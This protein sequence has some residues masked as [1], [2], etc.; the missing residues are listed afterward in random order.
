MEQNITYLEKISVNKLI[1]VIFLLLLII[2]LFSA[3]IIF[4]NETDKNIRINGNYFTAYPS[5]LSN[6]SL[7]PAELNQK[8]LNGDIGFVESVGK[9]MERDKYITK[10]VVQRFRTNSKKKA[11]RSN[12]EQNSDVITASKFSIEDNF[13][14]FSYRE[15]KV[16]HKFKAG[17]I[18]SSGYIPPDAMGAVGPS[19][20]VY[21]VNGRIITYNKNTCQQDGYLNTTTDNFFNSVKTT[22][23]T[24]TDPRVRYDRLSGRWFIIMGDMPYT[25]LGR[26]RIM[27][28]VS[29]SSVITSSSNFT[30][31]YFRD[32]NY[33]VDF[34][35]L[36]VDKNAVYIGGNLFNTNNGTY[37]GTRGFV[38]RKSS[39]LGSGPIVRTTFTF[40]SKPNRA[41]LFSPQGIDNY[42]P[43]ATEGYFIGV[44]NLYY[45]LLNLRRISNPGGNPSS[46]EDISFSTALT[47]YS[48][49]KVPHL[50][51]NYGD[52]AKIDAS[53]DRLFYAHYR[54]INNVGSLWTSHN[55][56]VDSSGVAGAN[57]DRNGIRWYEIKGI[58]T[59][60]T[61]YVYRAGTIYDSSLNNPVYYFFPTMTVNGQG[62]VVVGFTSAGANQ[63]LSA[64]YTYRLNNDP[65]TSFRPV[66]NYELSNSAYNLPWENYQSRGCRR[67]GDYS[68]TSLD[69]SD[70]MTIWTIQ[71][72]CDSTDSWGCIVG[73][74]LAPPPPPDTALTPNPSAITAHMDSVFV[75]INSSVEGFY[76]PGQGFTNRI[77]ASC[78]HGVIVNSITYNSPTSITLNLNT[79]N[80]QRNNLEVD[81]FIDVTITNPDGQSITANNFIKVEGALPVKLASFDYS[82]KERDVK[83]SWTTIEEINNSG[84]E[85]YRKLNNDRDNWNKIGF[86]KGAGNSKTPVTYNYFDRS[87]NKGIYRYKLKQI[88]YNGNFEFFELNN[89][90]EI[91]SPSKFSLLQNYPNPF[92]PKTRICFSIPE[93]TYV[94]LSVYDITGRVV[95]IL[96]DKKIESGYYEVE[97]NGMDLP[98]GI[99]FY[100][101]NTE[102]FTETKKMLLIK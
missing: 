34:P 81:I 22:G 73:K 76:D 23:W 90:V 47:T 77:S 67:W 37:Q 41:G 2:I 51:N 85:I 45:G 38:V 24:T 36:A 94:K 32:N 71:E 58:E 27:I 35:S 52:S 59:G 53:D 46:S 60:Q 84:F 55:L 96:I 16:S 72:Y 15:T 1:Y 83:L 25:G 28:A 87:L 5:V 13:S 82:V 43:N 63:Y 10:E 40:V 4:Q 91:G 66:I 89:S 6:D 17:N 30:F 20:F 26:N 100:V 86:I 11:D 65:P 54:K 75:T 68:F 42:D 39:I 74:I 8:S 19:Q 70:D 33:F 49:L 7:I 48:P 44:D 9:I 31:F 12:L 61:P 101:L 97:F 62:N 14:D 64:S 88:D 92:N 50:G 21:I 29:S 56:R 57:G 69:P 99:Y 78:S 102:R 3:F 80:I 18:V 79:Q 95:A 98:S 93:L